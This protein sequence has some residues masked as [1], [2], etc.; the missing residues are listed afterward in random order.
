MSTTDQGWPAAAWR[1]RLVDWGTAYGA[2]AALALLL[3]VNALFTPNFTTA[4]NL[5]NVLLQVSTPALVAVGMTLVLAT[6]GVDLSV[7]SIMAV[8][9][10]VA[11]MVIDR[12]AAAAL[13][14]GLAAAA[15][16]GALNGVLIGWYRVEPFIVTLAVQIAGRGV[17]QVLSN[18]GELVPFS[19]PTFEALGRGHVGPVPAQVVLAAGVVALAV[20]LVRATVFG[21]H[22]AAVGGNEAAARLCGVPVALTKLAAYTLSGLLAGLAGLIETARLGSTDPSNLGVGMEFGAIFA[23]VLGGTP[24]SGGRAPVLGAV[25][26]ALILTVIGTGFNMLLLPYAWALVLQAGVILF[27]VSLQAGRAE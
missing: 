22:L 16:C 20:F 19:N 5:W 25:A 7:G 15:A 26:G 14:A 10:A 12:G 3:V 27:I 6:G 2:P 17:A 8:S 13:L 4:A 24:L 18:E 9:S 1:S 21:R 11:V 23:A